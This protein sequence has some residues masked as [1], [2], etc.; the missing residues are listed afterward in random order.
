MLCSSNELVWKVIYEP[1]HDKTNK[2][3]VRPATT[4]ISLRVRPV[5]SVFPVRMKNPW[6]LR[7]PL[8]AKRRL[9][10][11]WADAQAELSLRRA[12]SHFVGFVMRRLKYINQLTYGN[13]F[14]ILWRIFFYQ[15]INLRSRIKEGISFWYYFL[16]IPYEC[17]YLIVVDLMWKFC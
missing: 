15:G 2:M 14:W 10:S 4:Q 16:E 12:H 17:Q 8:S 11:D 13:L 1:P 6:V 5:W 7:Y 3:T 9:W